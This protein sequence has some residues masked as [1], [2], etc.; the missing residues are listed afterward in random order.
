MFKYKRN[1][2]ML[3]LRLLATRRRLDSTA[4]LLLA[5]LLVLL[6]ALGCRHAAPPPMAAAPAQGGAKVVYVQPSD[7]DLEELLPPPPADG[8]AAHRAEIE[9]MLVLQAQRTPAEEARCKS[10]EEVTVFADVLGPWFNASNLPR[11]AKL[12]DVVY[13]QAREVSAASKIIWKRKRPPLYDPRIKPCVVLEKSYSYV[14]GHATR[15][16]TWGSLLAEIFPEQ[17]EAIMDRGKQIGTDRTLAGM[18]YPSDVA[19]GQMLG[20]EIA[21]HL[22]ADPRFVAEM[23]RVKQECRAAAT[24]AATRPTTRAAMLQ[25]P[26][27]SWQKLPDNLTTPY[28]GAIFP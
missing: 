9:R 26:S 18:H 5:L 1:S 23:A 11:T 4:K 28:A 7:F 13:D 15:G 24:A 14:S 6:P 19:G 25:V 21:R 3:T 22:L 27:G 17:R 12:M 10:E 20:A 8:S 16:I 2:L